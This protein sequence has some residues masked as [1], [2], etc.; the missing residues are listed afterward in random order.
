MEIESRKYY[1]YALKDSRKNPATIFYIGKGTGSRKNEHLINPDN[2][3]KGLFITDILNSGQEVIVTILSDGLT[4]VQ[5]LKLEAELIAT[6]GT[7]KNG[8][9]LKNSVSPTGLINKKYEILNLPVGL[10]D[11]AQLGLNFLKEAILEFLKSNP[12]GAKN[13]QIAKYLGLQSDNNGRQQDYL[14]YSILGILMKE[15]SIMKVENSIY[16]IKK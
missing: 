4:E 14:T 15:N 12:S 5:A 11:K 8:G 7:E 1:I 3:P 10:Y 2:T 16:K 6:F 13:N 9:I